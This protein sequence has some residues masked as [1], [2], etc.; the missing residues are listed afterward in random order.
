[1]R[2]VSHQA[3]SPARAGA[4]SAELD[5]QTALVD[6]N[7]PGGMRHGLNNY[8]DWFAG[9]PDMGGTY[10]GYDGMGPPWNDERVHGYRF[11]IHALDVESLGLSGAFTG[12]DVVEAM[13]GQR[14]FGHVTLDK[15]ERSELGVAARPVALRDHNSFAVILGVFHNAGYDQTVTLAQVFWLKDTVRKFHVVATRPLTIQEHFN[16][17]I[18]LRI[19]EAEIELKQAE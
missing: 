2:T 14:I 1:M 5:L 7:A 10:A 16:D 18:A 8:T 15:S 17:F 4:L 13:K 3:A 11:Q 9:D 12:P 6:P 19:V